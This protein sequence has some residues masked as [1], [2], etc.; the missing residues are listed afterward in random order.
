MIGFY[1]DITHEYFSVYGLNDNIIE[2]ETE[3][4]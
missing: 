4:V 1:A 3:T 2:N